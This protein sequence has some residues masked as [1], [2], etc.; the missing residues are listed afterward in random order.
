MSQNPPV[1]FCASCGKKFPHRM[2]YNSRFCPYCG[3]ELPMFIT[4]VIKGIKKE[5]DFCIYCGHFLSDQAFFNVHCD[6][7][8]KE[9]PHE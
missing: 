3:A 7:C 6:K 9:L 8:G 1:R 4:P 2:P 5:Y